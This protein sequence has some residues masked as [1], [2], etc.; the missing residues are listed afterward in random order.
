MTTPPSKNT[1]TEIPFKL[2]Q[3]TDKQMF[4]RIGK[5]F[6]LLFVF[7][8]MFDT[9]FDWFLGIMDLLLE[10]VHII[11]EAIEYSIELILE[12]TLQTNHQD[13]EIIIVNGTIIISLFILYRLFLTIPKL[14]SLLCKSWSHYIERKSSYWES[15]SLSR[16]V[17]VVSTYCVGFTCMFFV[18]T[19]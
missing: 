12:N 7:I 6:A 16:K 14:Y 15:I 8:F 17:K 11:I 5:R 3:E 10:G 9:L 19:L 18:L 2:N 13:S 1:T 4:S